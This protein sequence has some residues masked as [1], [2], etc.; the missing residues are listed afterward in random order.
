MKDDFSGK[1]VVLRCSW[2]REEQK[3]DLGHV[4]N[5]EAASEFLHMMTGGWSGESRFEFKKTEPGDPINPLVE[6]QLGQ[7]ACCKKQ[8]EGYLYGYDE[9]PPCAG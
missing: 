3:L 6:T 1:G 2:C 5:R 8:L 4:Y 9:E 7:S